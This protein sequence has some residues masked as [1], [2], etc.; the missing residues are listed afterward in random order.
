MSEPIHITT[1]L[2]K[3]VAR[4]LRIGDKV[5]ISGII[6]A[7][8][9]AAHQRFTETLAR[10]EALPVDLRGQLIYYLGPSPAKPGQVIGAAGPTTASRMDAHTPA[11]FELGLAGTIGKGGRSAAVMQAMRD[12]GGVYFAA[13]GGA[14]ALLARCITEYTVVDYAD[15]GP[16]A[17]ALLRVENFPAT[18][19]GDS[20]GGDLYMEG[21][22]RY[23]I[24]D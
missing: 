5:L 17:L 16:E 23:A 13:T 7:A 15:L 3:D 12:H 22:K 11:L 20:C 1:P 24:T 6:Y 10:G 9:D 2:D 21:K 4:S 8:R 18:V 19:V 14:G